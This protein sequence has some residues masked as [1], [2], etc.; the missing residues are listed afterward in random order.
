MHYMCIYMYDCG[1]NWVDNWKHIYV[2]IKGVFFLEPWSTGHISYIL[3][4]RSI[5]SFPRH[6]IRPKMNCIIKKLFIIDS[7]WAKTKPKR[8]TKCMK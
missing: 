4:D 7:F 6:Q 8:S 1:P 2:S 5:V 3:P